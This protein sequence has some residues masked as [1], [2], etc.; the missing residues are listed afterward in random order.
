MTDNSLAIATIVVVIVLSLALLNLLG[1]MIF[2][3]LKRECSSCTDKNIQLA[4][5]ECGEIKPLQ[6]ISTALQLDKGFVCDLEKGTTQRDLYEDEVVNSRG[7]EK[8][9]MKPTLTGKFDRL[10]ETETLLKPFHKF[11]KLFRKDSRKQKDGDQ[12]HH[13]KFEASDV[14]TPSGK[15]HYGT[16]KPW[17]DGSKRGDSIYDTLPPLRPVSDMDYGISNFSGGTKA[18]ILSSPTKSEPTALTPPADSV[19]F[20]ASDNHGYHM[21]SDTEHWR[22]SYPPKVYNMYHNDNAIPRASLI[23]RAYDPVGSENGLAALYNLSKN[24]HPLKVINKSLNDPAKNENAND[25]V[26]N[27]L[28]EYQHAA[29]RA[30][31]ARNLT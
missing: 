16:P 15:P 17:I 3:R 28:D 31:P 6:R 14:V 22:L 27:I 1:Y 19:K 18:H 5:W 9:R 7:S 23:E 29:W 2:L 21:P 8:T 30:R 26:D 20:G 25:E 10:M 12:S 24:E 11:N 4:K 13:G